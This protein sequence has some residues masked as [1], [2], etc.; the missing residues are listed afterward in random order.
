MVKNILGN[1]IDIPLLGLREASREVTGSLHE[2]FTDESYAISNCFLLS[3][4][5]VGGLVFINY[6]HFVLPLFAPILLFLLHLLTT[7]HNQQ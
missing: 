6:E 3:T 2:L 5:Q 1:G 7:M 4:S